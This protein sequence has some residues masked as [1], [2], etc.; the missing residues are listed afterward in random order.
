MPVRLSCTRVLVWKKGTFICIF[1]L[2]P[3]Q[4]PR[5]LSFPSCRAL[6][7]LYRRI[8]EK[9]LHPITTTPLLHHRPFL[10]R[11]A[12]WV[13]FTCFYSLPPLLSSSLT[14]K[15]LLLA[16]YVMVFHL[17]PL[18]SILCDISVFHSS[19]RAWLSI[20]THPLRVF[21]LYLPLLQL[22]DSFYL[23]RLSW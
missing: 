1:S 3:L 11:P 12:I 19:F 6:F 18:P 5:S 7:Y 2:S 10:L 9:P 14:T 16:P 13:P 23:L 17:Y 15:F 4:S 20:L 22:P 21:I 8:V